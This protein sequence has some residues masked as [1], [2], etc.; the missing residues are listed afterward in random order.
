GNVVPARQSNLNFQASG[1]VKSINVQSGQTV[2]AGD[3]LASV[4][5]T[6]QQ[7]AVKQAQLNLAGAQSVLDKLLQPVDANTLAEAQAVV[8][9]A[10]GSYQSKASS[11]AS[12]ADLKVYQDKVTQ[13]QNDANYAKLQAMA[14]GGQYK[15][16]DP[17]YTSAQAAAGQADFNV[18]LA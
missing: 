16:T 6:A 1:V 4:D 11:G 2:K 13:A 14:A 7:A 10:E 12:A 17:Q 3:V 9:S 15:T 8:K 5:D 18:L